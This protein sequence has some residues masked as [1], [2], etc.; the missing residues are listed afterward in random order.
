M[1]LAVACSLDS[2]PLQLYMGVH[3]A[4]DVSR[5]TFGHKFNHSAIAVCGSRGVTIVI[6]V[7]SITHHTTPGL[8]SLEFGASV[9]NAG[10]RE[11]QGSFIILDVARR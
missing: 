2:I 10:I 8:V 3:G 4:A 5:H 7:R 6:G 11:V 9:M 1:Y